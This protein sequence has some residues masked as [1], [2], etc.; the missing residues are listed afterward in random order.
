MPKCRIG[1]SGFLYD[2]WRGNFYPEELPPK[3]W[4]SFYVGKLN[5][6]ELNVTFYRLLKKEAFERWH[7]ET[8]PHFCFSLKG[9]RLITHIKKLKDVEL[10]LSTFFNTTSPLMN[11]FE[12]VLWQLP[13]NFRANMKSL[14]DFIQL[15]QPY[16]VRHVFEFRHKSWM[17]KKVFKLLSESNIAICMADWPELVNEIPLTANFIYIR[18]HGEAGNYATDYSTEQLKQDANK[19]K[20]HLKHGKD[21]YIYFNN[22]ALGYAPK[23]AMELSEMLKKSLPNSIKEEMSGEKP[24][25]KTAKQKKS[26]AK[27]IKTKIKT[28]KK[29]TVK[30]K[31]KKPAIRPKKR[32]VTRKIKKVSGKKPVRKPL[33]KKPA[34]SAAKKKRR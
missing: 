20:D 25:L 7:G 15:L 22:D 27:K 34:K 4:L 12:V 9:S 28:K 23:N 11:K 1:C 2:S 6:V 5:T 13:P 30:P 26:G 19:I 32:P 14:S 24:K 3:K 31:K 21:V 8:P 16:P 29:I 10:P 33:K 17:N 18:R